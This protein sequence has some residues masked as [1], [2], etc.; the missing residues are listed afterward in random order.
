MRTWILL[1]AVACAACAP[2]VWLTPE[3]R[4]A[5]ARAVHQTAGDQ[6]LLIA[7]DVDQPYDVLADI[8][9]VVRKRGAF[10]DEP[11]QAGALA[12]LREQ[13]AR[14]GAHAVILIAFGESGMSF[15]SYNELRGHGRAIRFR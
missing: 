11:T 4:W 13:A 10:G 7:T 15:W 12:A 8:E 5:N 1:A 9:V 6:I 3:L 2:E 14:L